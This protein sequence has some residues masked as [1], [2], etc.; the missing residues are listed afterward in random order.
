MELQDALRQAI[1]DSGLSYY[2]LAKDSGVHSA[3]ISR[4]AAG[5]RDLRLKTASRIAKALRLELTTA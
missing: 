5:E 1:V 4:F 3:V 2:R